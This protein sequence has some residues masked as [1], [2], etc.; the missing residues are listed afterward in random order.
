MLDSGRIL[1]SSLLPLPPLIHLPV[2]LSH[3][4]RVTAAPETEGQ[5]HYDADEDAVPGELAQRIGSQ[6]VR[7]LVDVGV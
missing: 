5:Q 4:A 1:Y 2:L 6:V 3:T 7:A